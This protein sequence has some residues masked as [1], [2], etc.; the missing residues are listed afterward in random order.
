M[1]RA[2]HQF[3]RVTCSLS[4][5]KAWFTGL[6]EGHRPMLDSGLGVGKSVL[7]SSPL[8]TTRYYKPSLRY[9]AWFQAID[10]TDDA[11]PA[12]GAATL[13]FSWHMVRP[14]A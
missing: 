1:K 3:I 11:Q 9:S 8:D 7:V 2:R 5:P 14:V 13:V 6:Q 4:E 10:F 12:V